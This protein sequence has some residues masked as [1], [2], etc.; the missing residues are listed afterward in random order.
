MATTERQAHAHTARPRRARVTFNQLLLAQ[1][2]LLIALAF[3]FGAVAFAVRGYRPSGGEAA[4]GASIGNAA[5]QPAATG[6]G[7]TITAFSA[8][9]VPQVVAV[10][11][12]AS[13]A[14]RWDRATYEA[15]AGDISFVVT[16]KS[17]MPHNFAIEGPGIT[18]QSK[19]FGSNT[20]STFTVKG[21]PP[22]EYLIICNYPGHRAAGM[23][24]KLIVT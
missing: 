3:V 21:L 12:D 2:P 9:T 22:G 18:A 11:A 1:L 23:I 17:A 24:A 6:G 13:G 4:A 10:A 19:N 8:D 16:N 14:L 7:G 15:K 5:A 20:T